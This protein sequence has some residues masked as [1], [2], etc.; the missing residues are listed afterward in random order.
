MYIAVAYDVVCD[1]RRARLAKKLLDFLPRV[2]KSVFE[3]N[4]PP[5]RFPAL[6]RTILKEVDLAEDSV[7]IYHL[8][9]ACRD[10]VVGHGRISAGAV[11]GDAAADEVFDK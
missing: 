6:E 11:G 8:C 5:L 2:Q 9:R 1:R 4:L 3:G 7:R 10:R